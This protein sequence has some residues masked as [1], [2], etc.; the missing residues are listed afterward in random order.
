M[1]SLS[2]VCNGLGLVGVVGTGRAIKHHRTQSTVS[3]TP[4]PPFLR[5]ID[6]KDVPPM[7]GGMN[8][9]PAMMFV[10][11]LAHTAPD[12]KAW[13][14]KDIDVLNRRWTQVGVMRMWE[15]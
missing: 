6:S 5:T 11:L 1:S 14:A 13:T 3:N 9:G 8:S 12:G 4:V 2:F 10:D 7:G 15:D